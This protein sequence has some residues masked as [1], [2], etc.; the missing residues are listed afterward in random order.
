V[1]ERRAAPSTRAALAFHT[2]SH[3]RALFRLQAGRETAMAKG[4]NTHDRSAADRDMGRD[5]ESEE[6][7]LQARLAKL[8]DALE[9]RQAPSEPNDGGAD[10][11]RQSLGA[12]T[13]LGL[14]ALAEF[15]TAIVVAPLI[16]W[17]IDAWFKTGPIF[18]I[19]FLILGMVAGLVNVY[20]MA[21]GAASTR[22]S[23]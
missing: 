3:Y 17:Q 10:S 18:L 21:V 1:L 5:A 13:N 11:A 12:A 4:K 23:K 20:R 2:G 15:V 6:A 8:S 19:I 22:G 7:S 16:G 14:R 9:K